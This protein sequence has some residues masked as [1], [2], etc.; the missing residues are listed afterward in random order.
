MRADRDSWSSA[1]RPPDFVRG[2]DEAPLVTVGIP[3]YDRPELL[4]QAL[5]NL[6][7]QSPACPFETVICDDG[8][9][10]DTRRIVEE[11]A[12][13]PL[14]Y[15]VNRPTLGP[16]AN[17]NRCVQLARGRWVTVLHEDDLLYPWFLKTVVPHLSENIAGLAVK[18][19]QGTEPPRLAEPARP[20]RSRL[21]AAVWF[22]KSSMT[23]F[24]GVVFRREAAA[25][26]GGFE[27]SQQGLADYAFWYDL[28]RLGRIE[29]LDATA[30][31][32][33][34][35]PGQWTERAWPDMLRRAHLLRLRIAREQLSSSPRLGRW[36]A[37]FYTA[38]MARAYARR[39]P[40]KP[41]ILARAERFERI[42]LNWISSGWVWAML[43]RLG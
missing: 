22:L 36:I 16:V 13:S 15:F 29:T 24:P 21:Y 38:R 32:Y 20:S 6:A 18:C 3:A 43:R 4:K 40:E 26:L 7:Q 17:W 2:I 5:A 27:E 25:S 28:A 39:F 34:V 1:S 23:P 30:A 37:R 42:P 10:P 8:G 19:V 33:R 9:R 11:S 35:N 14:R 41:A 31:F 12:V